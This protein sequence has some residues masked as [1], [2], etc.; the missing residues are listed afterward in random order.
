MDKPNALSILFNVLAGSGL[1]VRIVSG[2]AAVV[3]LAAPQ[4]QAVGIGAAVVTTALLFAA[5]EIKVLQSLLSQP[6]MSAP[7]HAAADG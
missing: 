4:A 5:G 7:R 1:S 3:G 6:G 2:G